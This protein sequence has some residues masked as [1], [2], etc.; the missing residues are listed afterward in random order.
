MQR[1]WPLFKLH[2]CKDLAKGKNK[3]ASGDAVLAAGG[4]AG[5]RR[6]MTEGLTSLTENICVG[7]LQLLNVKS[8]TCLRFGRSAGFTIFLHLGANFTLPK[9]VYK[10]NRIPFSVWSAPEAFEQFIAL[11][12]EA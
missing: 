2:K 7:I 10:D 5:R 8:C 6:C 9:C 1:H 3:T 11:M 12:W 4:D